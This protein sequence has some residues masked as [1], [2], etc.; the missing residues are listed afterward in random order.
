MIEK[1]TKYQTLDGVLHCSE[2]QAREHISA[3]LANIVGS[4]IDAVSH[5][6]R[7]NMALCT[8]AKI[9]LV[10][11]LVGTPEKARRL[12]SIIGEYV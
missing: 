8:K 6:L 1:I 7:P 2:A 4:M 12:K 10:D 11:K 5:E 9:A 3:C